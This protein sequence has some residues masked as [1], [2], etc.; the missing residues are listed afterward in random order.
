M[1]FGD[2]TAMKI[3]M[4]FFWVF[5]TCNIEDTNQG[6]GGSYCLFHTLCTSS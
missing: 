1:R 5:M 6:F 2:F 3:Q 4:L